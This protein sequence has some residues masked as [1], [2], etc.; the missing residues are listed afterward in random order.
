MSIYKTCPD[1]GAHLDPGERCD[2][3]RKPVGAECW[4]C[5][6]EVPGPGKGGLVV[7]IDGKTLAQTSMPLCRGC[8]EEHMARA[9]RAPWEVP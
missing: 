6:A 9:A 4:F 1:C 3:Q 5:G 8:V 2:C 7:I